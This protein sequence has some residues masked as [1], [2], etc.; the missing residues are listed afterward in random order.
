MS[1]PVFFST[2]VAE[3]A[4]GHVLTFGEDVAGHAVRVRRLGPGDELEVVDGSG[5][6]VRGTVS[7]ASANELGLHI[8]SVTHTDQDQP[9]LVLVQALAKSDRD[10]QAIEAA[11]EIGVDEVIPWAA[12]RSI[13][14]WPAKKREKLAA[15]WDN[16]LRAAS[17]QA[18]RSRFPLRHDLVRGTGLTSALAETDTVYVLH[19]A[20]ELKLSQALS[21]D[22]PANSS[23]AEESSAGE[24]SSTPASGRI[25]LVVGPEGGVSDAELDALAD[26]GAKAVLLGPTVLRSSSAGAAGLVMAQNSLGRW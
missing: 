25:V 3:A 20:A 7:S 18:R 21:T 26:V 14:D 15:K 2:Q 16:V 6:R 4:V 1:L 22:S 5:T 23:T 11:T 12:E 9:R 17:L 13:A 19:E 8:A 10:L 24:E